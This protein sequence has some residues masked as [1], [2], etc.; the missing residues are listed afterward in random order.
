M[1]RVAAVF[2]TMLLMPALVTAQSAEEYLAIRNRMA[3]S[4]MQVFA[5]S[6][7]L[8]KH[9]TAVALTERLAVTNCHI[10]GDAA[11]VSVKRGGLLSGARVHAGDTG[12]DICLLELDETVGVPA[13]TGAA[14]ALSRG[15]TVYAVGFGMGGRYAI[16]VGEVQALYPYEDGLIVR[17]N[18]SFTTG[19]SGGALFDRSGSLVGILTFFR[20][21]AQGVAYFAMPVEWVLQLRDPTNARVERSRPP[22]WSQAQT[23]QDWF[24]RAAGYEIDG[25]WQELLQAAQQWM[26]D[27]PSNPEAPRA[28]DHALARLAEPKF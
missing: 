15:E 13:R 21:G 16:S 23:E 2:C 12:H 6:H 28:R 4:I 1:R 19:A 26:L 8:L 20:K 18:A 3:P 5:K 10:V 7:G 22:L 24:L 11:S 25:Q 27:Q 14:A 9:G 17:T